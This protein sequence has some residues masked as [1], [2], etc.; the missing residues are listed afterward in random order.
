MQIMT[1]QFITDET[2]IAMLTVGQL[3]E[4]LTQASKSE[5][6]STLQQSG[7]RYVY[8]LRGIRNLFNVCHSTAQ[9]YKDGI[10]KGA[11]IQN[12][13][14]IIVDADMALELFANNQEQQS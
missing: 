4:V 6:T 8:G 7:K 3:K 1:T 14:K 13:A 10:L 5:Q 11:I 12:G 9:K 2:P